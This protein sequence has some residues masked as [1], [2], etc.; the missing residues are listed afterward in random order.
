MNSGHN[1]TESYRLNVLHGP[2]ALVFTDGAPPTLPLDFSWMGNLGLNGWVSNTDRGNVSGTATGIPAGFQG[3]VG[4]A[5][6]TAQYWSIIAADGTYTSSA[7]KPGTYTA[8]LYKEKLEV[9]TSPV[10][11]NAGSTTTLN[12]TST[13]PTPSSD[14]SELASGTERRQD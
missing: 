1:Q 5:N 6:A 8:T 11:V 9:A 10:I 2:Y 12:L 7:M 13:E 14:I 3:V 4:F